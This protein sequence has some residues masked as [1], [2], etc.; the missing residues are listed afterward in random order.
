MF[1]HYIIYLQSSVRKFQLGKGTEIYPITVI[2]K[3]VLKLILQGLF[4]LL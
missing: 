1:V 3:H 4:Y 2:V